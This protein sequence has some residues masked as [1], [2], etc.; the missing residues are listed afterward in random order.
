MTFAF[1][2]DNDE[3]EEILTFVRA[4][5]GT[6]Q[7]AYRRDKVGN[8][9][10][11]EII[12]MPDP[13]VMH[14]ERTRQYVAVILGKKPRLVSLPDK[15]LFAHFAKKV[16]PN[17]DVI[18]SED[19]IWTAMVLATGVGGLERKPAP[20]TWT[21]ENG[22]LVIHYYRHIPDPDDYDLM[23][24]ECT[25]TVDTNQDYTLECIDLGPPSE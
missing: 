11:I 14:G 2:L 8:L 7:E 5:L 3:A 23:V 18:E 20:P 12:T 4:T 15:A 1:I 9:A 24:Q 17:P 10:F 16:R 6:R 19:R 21:D 25:L 13:D 22:T